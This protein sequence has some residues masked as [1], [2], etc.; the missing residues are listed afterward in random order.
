MDKKYTFS[1]LCGIIAALRGENGCPWDKEQ[2]HESL[3]PCM[4]E[5][6][7]ELLAAIRIYGQTGNTENMQEELGDIL[8]QAVMHSQIAAEEKLFTIDDVIQTVSEKMIRR[9]PHVFADITA[10]TSDEA[11][12]NWE[13][14]KKQEKEGKAWIPSPLQEIPKELPALSRAVKVLKK[15]DKLYAPQGDFAAAAGCIRA[16]ACALAQ[17]D[18]K[19][20]EEALAKTLGSLLVEAAQIAR[21]KK[22]SLEQILTDKIEDII[23]QYEPSAYC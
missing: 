1:D 5:E 13:E 19:E 3:K 15:A 7:A 6:A 16:H 4:M 8:L 21:L 2:T 11:L 12:R 23:E 10:N 18:G 22:L 9:H 14:I 20:D 17:L